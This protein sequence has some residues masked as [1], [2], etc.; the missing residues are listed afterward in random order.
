MQAERFGAILIMP[1]PA[2]KKKSSF[3]SRRRSELSGYHD[4]IYRTDKAGLYIRADVNR[5]EKKIRL[6]VEDANERIFISIIEKGVIVEE[7]AGGEK[8]SFAVSAMMKRKAPVFRLLPN[9]IIRLING[10]YGISVPIVASGKRKRGILE[11]SIFFILAGG[12]VALI[13]FMFKVF[14]FPG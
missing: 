2:Q 5:L 8:N 11:R 9:D 1:L 3:W 6:L 7:T 10:H 14:L 12:V 4:S 13:S